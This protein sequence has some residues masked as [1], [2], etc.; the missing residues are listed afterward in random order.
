[1]NTTKLRRLQQV[2][3][4]WAQW[5]AQLRILGGLG[6]HARRPTR[7][8]LATG[9][10]VCVAAEPAAAL[11]LSDTAAKAVLWVGLMVAMLLLALM[12][13]AT[14]SVADAPDHEL[15]E[16]LTRIRDGYRSRA[17]GLLKTCVVVGTC[18]LTFAMTSGSPIGPGIVEAVIWPLVLLSF[19]LP[20][21]LAGWSLPEFD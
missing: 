16:M 19:G 1:M 7:R 14:R 13:N 5:D 8:W 2:R 3:A 12:G 17:Y 6:T 18:V 20:T 9:Y 4:R 21:L 15:D 10:L 11:L